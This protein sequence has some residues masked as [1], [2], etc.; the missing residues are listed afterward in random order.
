MFQM[1]GATHGNPDGFGASGS[2]SQQTPPLPPP[3]SLVDVMAAQTEFLRQ[4]VQGQQPHHQQRG[5]HNAPQPQV[6]GFS[7]FFGTQPP[8][9]SKT[10]EPLDADAW[11]R[12]TKSKFAL[13]TLPCSEANKA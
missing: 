8:L 13:L 6:V 9:F 3:P 12:T 5:V 4:I 1:V 10:E 7:E 2:W 11:I